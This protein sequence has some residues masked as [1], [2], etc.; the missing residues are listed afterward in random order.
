MTAD[1]EPKTVINIL[2]HQIANSYIL[3]LNYKRYHWRVFGPL[4]RDLHRLFD[5]HA[6]LVRAPI[7]ELGERVGILGGDPGS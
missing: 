5:E 3:Y 7:H 6:A 4:F 2:Q 1:A